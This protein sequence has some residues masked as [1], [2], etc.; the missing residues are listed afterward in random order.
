MVIAGALIAVISA[1]ALR[2][3]QAQ[4]PAGLDPLVRSYPPQI[5]RAL[6][7]LKNGVEQ[8]EGGQYAA[9]LDFL[10]S[11]EAGNT[12]QIG[13]YV[14]IYRANSCLMMNR[15]GQALELFRLFQKRYPT[16]P[17][18]QEAILGEC[19]ALLELRQ[20][21]DALSA[22]Q[23]PKLE[24][25]SEELYWRARALEDGRKTEEAVSLYLRVI[26]RY[27]NSSM[28]KS[29]EARLAVLAPKY[30][31]R[32]A[33]YEVLLER[34][35]NLL[36]AGRTR[37]ARALLL[38]LAPVRVSSVSARTRR[39]LL[40]AQAEY[41]LGK[42]STVL[43]LV[44][45]V[46]AAMPDSHAHAM[47]LEAACYRRLEREEYFLG[48]R[49][50]ALQAHPDSPYTE[51][52]LYSVA[53]YFEVQN[54]LEEAQLA[55]ATLVARFPK[56][57]YAERA[58]L[59]SAVLSYHLRRH[60]DAAREFFNYFNSYNGSRPQLALY[61]LGRCSQQAGDAAGAAELYGWCRR[62]A[63]DSYYG[64]RALEVSKALKQP[65]VS[66]TRILTEAQFGEIRRKLQQQSYTDAA[67]APPSP[68]VSLVIERV[69]QLA[70]A[71]LPDLALA[72]LRAGMRR[73]PEDRAL[74]YLTARFY[75]AKGDY[76]GV[77]STLRRAFPDYDTRPMNQ[78]PQEVW[79]M[80]FPVQHREVIIAESAKYGLDPNL[81]LGL[82]RQ[83]SAFS[84]EAHSRANARGLM[85]VLPSTGRKLARDARVSR[86][87]TRKLFQ[88]E[89]NV[90]L[91]TR[92]LADLLQH[93]SGRV[94][95]ALAAYNAGIDR[96]DRWAREFGDVDMAEFIDLIPFSETRDYVKQ[97]LTNTTFYALL[98]GASPGTSE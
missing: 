58:A 98:N 90:A 77:I 42:A 21:A 35:Q 61:W 46:P 49:D 65:A 16:S 92:H 28:G 63:G 95:F 34:A 10:V 86:Y 80:L 68:V 26:S 93:F 84:A 70:T 76:F 30:W 81:V 22:L 41:D 62:K 94:E 25:S 89:T 32:P 82:I 53:T 74:K 11:A 19:R 54:R 67:V 97:V 40:F 1:A 31:A 12:F 47:F 48:A 60:N 85:Q 88:P 18:L 36:R 37:D 59:R 15:N 79:D 55:Y 69:H 50:R 64:A 96:V 52:I 27:V 38:R 66:T 17:R 87:S 4:L 6:K 7:A 39:T 45:N 3:G 2:S 78:I 57:E 9:A 72:E 91:G 44:R 71:D 13:D 73:F 24:E 29:A 14:L 5:E 43:P 33:H 56:G 83:E 8:F 20:P 75:E 51:K 23:N